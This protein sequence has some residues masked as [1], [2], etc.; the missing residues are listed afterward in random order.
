[1]SWTRFF[2]RRYWDQERAREL[3][4][5]LQIETDE[6][7]ARGM[8]PEEAR[9]AAHRKLGNTTL[10]REEVYR[11]NSLGWLEALWQDLRYGLRQLKRNPGFTA[12]AVVTLALG[13]GANTAIFSVVRAV[14]FR[15]LPFRD[16][17]RLVI[18]IDHN[19][20]AGF[21][22][23]PSSLANVLDWRA[24]SRSFEGLAVFATGSFNLSGKDEPERLSGL[25]VSSNVLP[26]LGVRPVMGR[27]FLPEEDQPGGGH[28]VLISYGLWQRRF[29]SDPSIVGQSVQLDG[30]SATVIGVLPG[31]I[32]METALDCFASGSSQKLDLMAPLAA[33]L[34]RPDRG[35][36]FLTTV[37]RLKQGV[38][39]R[40]AQADMDVITSRLEK[41]YPRYNAGWGAT[42]LP[43][44]EAI[45]G[46]LR[47]PLLVL[48]GAVGLVLLIACA[49]VTSLLLA[50]AASRRKE[51]AIRTAIGAGRLRLFRQLMTESL[52]LAG[53]GGLLGLCIA[54]GATKLLAGLQDLELPRQAA[55]AV[56]YQ[57]LTF[58]VAISLLIG[59]LFGL[60]PALLCSEGSRVGI[61][62]EALKEGGRGASQSRQGNRFRGALVV[63][64]IALALS[65]LI[66]VGLL[67]RSYWGLL[68]VN[69]GFRPEGVATV[70]I[71]LLGAHYAKDTAQL[72]FVEELLR[73][74][75]ALPGVKSAAVSD[76]LPLEGGGQ[77]LFTA[78]GQT[79]APG[80]EPLAGFRIVSA[81]YLATMGIPVLEGRGF[82]DRDTRE[83][84]R[85]LMLNQTLARRLWPG[86]DGSTRAVGQEIQLF[87]RDAP[88]RIVGVVADVKRSALDQDAGREMYFLYDQMPQGWITLAVRSAMEPKALASAIR[89]TVRAVD[90]ELPVT[91]LRTLKEVVDASVASQRFQLLMLAIFGGLALVLAA[92]GIYGV[93]AY[94]VTQR[95]HEIGI[96]MALGASPGDMWRMVVRQALKL[97]G[98]GVII[99][100]VATLA[101]GRVLSGLLFGVKPTD[102]LTFGSAALLLVAIAI[103]AAYFPARRATKIDPIEALRYE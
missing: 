8:S 99:G 102:P 49:N 1:M 61:L 15:P 96:R 24:Q 63:S 95:A 35:N 55:I 68:H 20:S 75:A 81:G 66:G 4:A 101:L 82:T 98:V 12:V 67:L 31:G 18:V 53:M 30:R 57:V 78:V 72:G 91:H 56:D 86:P 103:L 23:F 92:V 52:V 94:S 39:L 2:R 21:P 27:G 69:P 38:T 46:D 5:Y 34:V 37:G 22:Q 36:R 13:I 88:F 73:K 25:R 14:L 10:I 79:Y 32:G 60:A 9:Y 97:A 19:L 28:V 80:R 16:P 59:F 62:S 93:I 43:L 85:V 84:P 33:D 76:G 71:Q 40:E 11:M 100:A 6:N 70:E 44:H 41:G 3:E 7:M 83:S 47:Q 42:V 64:E 87:G 77:W 17:G 51:V 74:V 29:G 26:L 58:T 50:R 65:L 48:L 90:R 54:E 45:V 89:S